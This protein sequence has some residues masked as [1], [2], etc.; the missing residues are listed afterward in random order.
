MC[1]WPYFPEILTETSENICSSHNSDSLML[2]LLHSRKEKEIRGL[3]LRAG[4]KNYYSAGSKK[5]HQKI[6]NDKRTYLDARKHD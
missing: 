3:K 5:I 6:T 1:I 4:G 2:R